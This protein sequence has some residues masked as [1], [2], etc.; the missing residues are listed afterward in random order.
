MIIFLFLILHWYLSLFGQTF[1][2]HR[3]S[4]HKMF[5]MSK[6]WEKFWYIYAWI[7]QG[8]SY[9]NARAYAILHRMHHA[10][11]DTQKDPHTPHFFKEVFSMMWHTRAVYNGVLRGTMQVEERFDKNFPV[12][13]AID[14]IADSWFSRLFFAGLYIAFYVAF[15]TQW[16]MFLFLPIHFLMGPVQGAVVNWAGHK[17]GYRNFDDENDQSK[18]TLIIDFLML[19]ELFQNNHHHAG[20]RPNFAAKWWEFDPVYPVIRLFHAIGII[21]LLPIKSNQ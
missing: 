14:R 17:Y 13:P 20:A 7:T 12:Y 1:Y 16:W 15:A 19:G 3:Y 4:A 11:S 8:S 5:T 2:L 9:L 18:N 6:S 10:Y 21:K